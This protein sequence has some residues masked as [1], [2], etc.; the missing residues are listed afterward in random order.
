MVGVF[1]VSGK[2]YQYVNPAFARNFAYSVDEMMQIEF[3]K[4][5]APGDKK[6]VKGKIAKLMKGEIEYS[7]SR[8]TGLQKDGNKRYLEMYMAGIKLENK[9]A[10][11]GAAIDITQRRQFEEALKEKSEQL[12]NLNKDLE[13]RIETELEKYCQQEQIM[14][15]QSKLAAMGEMVGAIAHQWRQPLTTVGV[16]MRNIKMAHKLDKLDGN[17]ID[18]LIKDAGEQI[19]YMSKTIDDFRNFF[20]PSRAKENFDVDTAVDETC[21]IIRSQ[22]ENDAIELEIIR[23]KSKEHRSTGYPNEFKQVLVNIINNATNAIV[24]KRENGQMPRDAGKISIEITGEDRPQNKT[25]DNKLTV[26]IANTG[27]KIAKENINRIFEPYFT[28]RPAGKGMGIGLYMSRTIIEEQMEGRI[29][30][31]NTGDGVLFTI[32]LNLK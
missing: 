16:I 13:N 6:A 3:T 22:M 21:S 15:Q 8:F 17:T 5:V 11:I 23:D 2:K 14:V 25:G 18:K 28:T 9:P 31:E 20:K 29:F 24:E 27:T 1:I 7:L 30:A 10:V 12:E 26:K 4:I 19:A 32:E